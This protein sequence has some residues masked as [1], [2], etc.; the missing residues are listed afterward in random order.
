M[1][2]EI[3]FQITNEKNVIDFQV[4]KLFKTEKIMTDQVIVKLWNVLVIFLILGLE[5][6]L[7]C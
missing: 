1:H 6:L 5:K 7:T 2:I 3:K 4:F